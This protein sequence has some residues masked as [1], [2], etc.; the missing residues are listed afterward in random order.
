MSTS[1]RR[2]F[3]EANR[4]AHAF[5]ALF[6]LCYDR[7]EICGSIR[8]RKPDIGDAEHLVIPRIVKRTSTDGLFSTEVEVNALWE[9]A[10]KLVADG[11]VAKHLYGATGFRWGEKYRG[12]EFGGML[13]EIWTA[14]P[15]NWGCKSIIRTGPAE[16]SERVV[17]KLKMGGMY[18]QHEGDLIHVG[19]G[20]VVPVPDEQ[21]YLRLAGLPWVEPEDRA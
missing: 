5:R 14:T 16:Y 8:R 4:A 11:V 17:T 19:T 3:D 1:T 2:T 6:D 21:T 7:W 13:H 12:M 9:G 18:R 20:Q 15:T 10:D